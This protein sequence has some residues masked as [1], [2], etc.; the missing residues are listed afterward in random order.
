METDHCHKFFKEVRLITK[1]HMVTLYGITYCP[2]NRALSLDE[3]REIGLSDGEHPTI[4]LTPQTFYELVD[5]SEPLTNRLLTNSMDISLS[6]HYRSK[7]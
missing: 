4:P 5:S 1:G 3:Q 6:N 2:Y 7:N